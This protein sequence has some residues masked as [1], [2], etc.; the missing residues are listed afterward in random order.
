[1]RTLCTTAATLAGFALLSTEAR[2]GS[3]GPAWEVSSIAQPTIF[4]AEDN[5]LCTRPRGALC[6][7]YTVTLTNVGSEPTDPAKGPVVVADTLPLGLKLVGLSGEN[8]GTGNHL[9]CNPSTMTCTSGEAIPAGDTLVVYLSVEVTS[10]VDKVTNVVTVSGGGAPRIST[11]PPLTLPNVIGGPSTFGIAAFGFAAHDESGGLDRQAGDHPYGV[12]STVNL[13]TSVTTQLDGSLVPASV[14]PP[15]DLVVY[16]PLGFVGD[17]SAAGH[18]TETQLVG[19]HG[20]DL[21]TEC[22]AN[23]RVGTLIAFVEKGTVTGTLV[24]PEEAGIVTGIYNMVPEAGYPAQFGFKYAG[25]P[26]PLYASLVHTG[27]GYAV[28]VG[29]PGIPITVNV[30]GVGLTF[31][32]DPGRT[33]GEPAA[34]RAFFT[35]PSDCGGGPLRTRAETDSWVHPRQWVSSESTAY[36]DITG[37]N[38]LQFEPATEMRPEVTQAEAPSGYQIK[39]K[40]PQTPELAPIL[41]TPQLKNVTMTLP[42]GMT[43]SPGAGDGLQ[44]CE[45]TGPSGIDMPT[46]LPGGAQRTPTE[47]GEGEAIGPDGMSHLTPGH[48][49]RQSQIG[50][51]ELV[52]PVLSSPLEGRLYVAQPKCGGPGQ[53]LCTAADATNGNLFGLYLEAEGSGVVVKLAGSASIDPSTGRITARFLENPQLPVSE[54]TIALKGGA[55]APLANPRQCGAASSNSDLAPWSAPETPD[56]IVSSAPFQVSW[57][58]AT[59]PCPA[60]LPFAPTLLAGPTNVRAGAFGSFTLTIGRGDRQ[61][62]I[63]RVQV[64]MPPGLLGMLSKVGLCGEGQAN[65]GTCEAASELG[66]VNVAAGSGTHPL[67]VTGKVYLTGPYEGAPFGLSVVVP[68]VA[69]PFNLG[70]VVVRS[71]IDIDPATSAVTITTDPLPQLRDGI[72]LRIQTLNV[73]VTRAGFLF[74]PT[75]CMGLQVATSIEAAQGA[76]ANLTSPVSLEGCGRLPFAPTFKASTSARTSKAR[77]ASLDVKVASAAGQANIGRVVVRLPKQLPARLT[78]LQKACTEATFAQNPALC[79]PQSLV[80]IAKAVT[81]VLSDAVSGPVYLV[82]HGGAAFPD[83]VVILQGEGVRVN[84]TGNT[85]IKGRITTSTFASVP[86]VPVSSF[87]LRLPEG[88]HSALSSNLPAEARGSFCTTKLAMRTTI[89]GQNGAQITQSTKVAVTGCPKARPTT[90]RSKTV[91][92]R[93]RRSG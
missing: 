13:D 44:G 45:A 50:T 53:P 22:P 30:E 83:V 75:H 85:D 21:E 42:E 93:A 6:D 86:D 8:I 26:I 12:T 62:D 27:S 3:P 91:R 31:F 56:A 2:A 67:W 81:P 71:R 79:P 41:A 65:E 20:R 72:P 35:N 54:V 58:A 18:C 23:S 73:A 33:N 74:N 10:A 55:R 7:K 87:E 84:L 4:S 63:A 28:R 19:L 88:S 64:H 46:D 57:D 14:E 48:C 32:G 11:S 61:Q 25:K 47:A 52:T 15:K 77:G 40:L 92:V 39:I 59:A 29:T 17:P 70:N 16:L 60:T 68:A 9:G 69:G 34:S 78:T 89:T 51:V 43:L 66:S 37:C 49:P 36:P 5:A 90:K 76:A 80:G 82:S 1:M 38:L 24:P